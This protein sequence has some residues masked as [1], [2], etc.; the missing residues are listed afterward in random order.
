MDASAVPVA[1][2]IEDL[3]RPEAYPHE[4]S[5]PEIHQTHISVVFLAGAHAYKIKKPVDLG[6]LDFTTLDRRRHY[7][8]EEVRLNRRLAPSVY[9][10]VVP[11]T[12]VGGRHVFGGD[13]TP[14]EYAVHME[15]LPAE[16]TLEARLQR[17]EPLEP[18]LEIF[19]RRLA[20]FHEQA[21]GGLE[22]ARFGEY[23]IVS[24]NARENLDQSRDQVGRTVSAAVFSRLEAALERAL[25][26]L[27]PLIEERAAAG[28][29]RDTHGDLHLEHVYALPDR[30]AP[31]DLV[32]VDCI[33]FNRRFRYADPVADM[34]FLAM[35]LVYHGR[36]DLAERF[37]DAYFRSSDDAAGRTLLPFY[38]SY[39]AAV[40]G[41]VE[42]I[43]S[44]EDEVQENQRV[45]AADRA[46]G[47]WLLA[48]SEL[49][50]PRERPALVLV[51]G[52]P[53]T[54]KSTL[55]NG[56]ASAAD[57]HVVSSDRT[58]K[59]LA[60]LDPEEPARAPFEEGIYAPAWT[61]RTYATCLEEVRRRFL[62]GERVIVDASFRD[63]SRRRLF[64]D[65]AR[66]WGVRSLFVLCE[67]P[68]N[69]VASRM[70]RRGPG[71]SDADWA[72][73]QEAARH[74]EAPGPDTARFLVTV[75]TAGTADEALRSALLAMRLAGL[76]D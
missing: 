26:H 53:G 63:E 24:G 7:C 54:G 30:P 38:R 73:Y 70:Q 59:S 18:Y 51:G 56:L 11:I 32:A 20:R 74:W 13:G 27:R 29:P 16:A 43:L 55:A 4:A 9:L 34:A 75:D 10:G 31:D 66:E 8:R 22:V 25:T 69:L 14:V 17:G 3:A 35:D 50:S 28:V 42:G 47:H 52:L 62:E 12:V 40:R 37:A 76:A 41:K 15:R 44:G 39:R 48:L 2:L 72:V 58:R 49:A 46:R 65:Q 45:R 57:L 71:P 61:E 64:L 23:E 21:A 60:G 5:D 36:P 67:A 33:E 6:F 1:R 68:A 19:G